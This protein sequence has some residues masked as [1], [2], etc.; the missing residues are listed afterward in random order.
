MFKEAFSFLYDEFG[1]SVLSSKQEKWGY[2]LSASNS[3]TGLKIENEFRE[4]Y[5]HVTLYKLIDG[6]IVENARIIENTQNAAFYER[7]MTGFGLGWILS[8][9]NPEVQI[10]P[11]YD[12]PP[13]SIFHDEQNGQWN[14]I[15]F[16]ASRLKEYASDILQGDF[17]IFPEL[18]VFVKAEYAKYFEERKQ[19]AIERSGNNT[20]KN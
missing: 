5:I 20:R 16:V 10:K 19:A 4:A 12:Y 7:P 14:Y 17:S 13:E 8:F 9:R 3:T 2:Y 18:D 6:K 15:L 1:F 11:M